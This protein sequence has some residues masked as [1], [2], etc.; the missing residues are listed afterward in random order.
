MLRHRCCTADKCIPTPPT[1]A[2][3]L[4][5]STATFD[6]TKCGGIVV[7]D[8]YNTSFSILSAAN[9]TRLAAGAH[10]GASIAAGTA[11]IWA[12]Q[13]NGALLRGTVYFQT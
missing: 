11:D 1:C 8:S 12:V 7:V 6:G 13:D 9:I 2:H 4:A 3:T 5:Y 10:S